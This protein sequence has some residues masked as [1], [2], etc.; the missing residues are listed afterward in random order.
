MNWKKTLPLLAFVLGLAY[1]AIPWGPRNP[2]PGFNYE[3][4]GKL[5]VQVGGRIKPLDTVARNNLMLLSERQSVEVPQEGGGT[6]EVPAIVWLAELAARPEV[7]D[8]WPVFRFLHPDVRSTLGFTEEDGKVFSYKELEPRFEQV[9]RLFQQLPENQERWDSYDEALARLHERIT[10]YHRLLHSFHPLGNTTRLLEEYRA[11]QSII[12]PGLAELQQQQNGQP[13]NE[14]ILQTFMG[15]ADRYLR[16]SKQAMLRII[17]PSGDQPIDGDW[18]NVGDSLLRSI[19]TRTIDPVVREYAQLTQSYHSE[20][21]EEFNAVAGQIRSDFR[22]QYPG[23]KFRVAFEQRFN[24]AAPFY[25]ASVVYVAVLLL[26]LISWLR[27]GDTLR[28]T[29]SALLVA[30][31]LVQTL[32]LFAR[33]YIQDR[34]PVTNLYSSAVFTGWGAVLLGILMERFFRNGFGAATAALVGFATL[35]IAHHLS[36]SGDTLELMRAVL[37]SNFWLATHVTIITIGYSAVFLAGGLALFYVI[38]G[39]FTNGL[40]KKMEKTLGNMVYGITCFALLFSFVGTMLGGIWADQ[41]WGRFWGW[42]PKENGALLLVLWGAVMLHA[43]WGGLVRTRGF[44]NMAI[45]GNVITSWSW[46]GTNMLG[47]GLHSYGFMDA[48]F[49]WLSVFVVSQVGF[50]LIGG[51][52]RHLWRSASLL[53]VRK[54]AGKGSPPSGPGTATGEV[55]SAGG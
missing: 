32:G 28:P 5:P 43:R 14:Q 17:P 24:Q 11:Y 51:L 16:L 50:M 53:G 49:F 54:P 10:R 8:T 40:D 21:E 12:G 3:S 7:A 4:F 9:D 13:Y 55:G 47:V 31:F 46:F 38:R 34:P 2:G 1:V 48:A 19:Q 45:F 36:L 30:A 44:M 23:E 42:D 29:A 33:M 37:D 39:V 27:W 26:V 41:S 22:A 35:I 25:R 52:P 18:E 15:F 20:D 6:V